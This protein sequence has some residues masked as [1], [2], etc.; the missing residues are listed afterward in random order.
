MKIIYFAN[1]ENRYSDTTEK[2]ISSAFT[3]L[4]HEVVQINERDF[5]IE[6]IISLRGDLFLFH[7]GGDLTGLPVTK[8]IELLNKLTIPKVCWYFD[9]AW[10]GREYW[11]EAVIPYTNFTFMSDG[12]F[13]KRHN[14]PNL[15]YLNQGIGTDD[16]TLGTPKPQYDCDVA[17]VGATYGERLKLCSLLKQ[18]YGDRFK[19]FKYSFGRNLYDLCATAKIIVAP[20]WPSTD[21]YW[22]SRVYMITGSGGFMLHPRLEGLKEEFENKKNIA[23]Y[24]DIE[25]LFEKIDYYLEHEEE[26]KAIQQAGYELTTTKYSYLERVKSLLNICQ[27]KKN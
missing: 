21:F 6:K 26:R 3:K 24:H 1:F 27:P 16:I 13:I 23:F 2:H 19:V 14:Y 17:F 11:L 20:K 22:S 7:K 5:D 25:S 10:E 4:G 12:S 18:R 8:L 9:K 15:F